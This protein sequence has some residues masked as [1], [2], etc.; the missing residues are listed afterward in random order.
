[1][2]HKL[3][4]SL[5]EPSTWTGII[6]LLSLIGVHVAPE[7]QSYIIQL[8]VSLGALLGVVFKWEKPIAPAPVPAVTN[9]SLEDLVRGNQ[10]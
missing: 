9:K 5:K 2:W 8:G 4:I 10:E 7:Y 1:M 3:G 6:A